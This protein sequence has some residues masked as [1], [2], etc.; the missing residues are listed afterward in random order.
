MVS[1]AALEG[2]AMRKAY[3]DEAGDD[4]DT[5]FTAYMG[6]E[7]DT[8]DES[9]LGKATLAKLREGELSF[10]GDDDDDSDDDSDE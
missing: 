2:V 4:S 6:D 7:D 8:D 1:D 5:D 9:L 10:D 3:L